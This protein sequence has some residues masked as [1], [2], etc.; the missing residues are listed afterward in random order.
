M[1]Q[2]KKLKVRYR[3]TYVLNKFGLAM[4]KKEINGFAWPSNYAEDN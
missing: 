3:K 4:V 2:R 1:L